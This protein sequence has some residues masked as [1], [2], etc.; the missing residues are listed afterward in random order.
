M[1]L[2]SWRRAADR[3]CQAADVWF[4]DDIVWLVSLPQA[5][6]LAEIERGIGSLVPRTEMDEGPLG[7]LY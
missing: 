7:A 2:T 6:P 1:Y 5:L 4:M 3:I